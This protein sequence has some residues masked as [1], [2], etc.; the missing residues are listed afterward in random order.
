MSVNPHLFP[1]DC[2]PSLSWGGIPIDQSLFMETPLGPGGSALSCCSGLQHNT[3]TA[4]T[5]THEGVMMSHCWALRWTTVLDSERSSSYLSALLWQPCSPDRGALEV[6]PPSSVSSFIV[7]RTPGHKHHHRLFLGILCEDRMWNQDFISSS[8]LINIPSITIYVSITRMSLLGQFSIPV[9][10]LYC[11]QEKHQASK[12]Q[13]T[14][15]IGGHESI[16]KYLMLTIKLIKS[17]TRP[18]WPQHSPD[19]NVWKSFPLEHNVSCVRGPEVPYRN[20]LN[21]VERVIE[22]MNHI[23]FLK[24]VPDEGPCDNTPITEWIQTQW[25]VHYDVTA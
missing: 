5:Q 1:V 16:T 4:C 3:H 22:V 21:T 14:K 12:D 9:L 8:C 6:G 17:T 19:W 15:L 2:V 10:N 18:S 24:W 11:S 23:P 25:G 13:C 7:D 20:G